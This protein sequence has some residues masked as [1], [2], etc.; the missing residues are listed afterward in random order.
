MKDEYF[1][2][3]VQARDRLLSTL[4][5]SDESSGSVLDPLVRVFLTRSTM[6]SVLEW[7]SKASGNVTFAAIIELQYVMEQ[8]RDFD[9]EQCLET[10]RKLSRRSREFGQLIDTEKHRLRT[11]PEAG[12][13]QALLEPTSTES[14]VLRI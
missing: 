3:M 4:I 10:L 14:L 13:A 12:E 11:S 9:A 1:L 8:L 6:L 2:D 7:G 5:D